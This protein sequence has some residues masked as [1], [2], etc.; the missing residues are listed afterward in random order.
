[1]ANDGE[2]KAANSSFSLSCLRATG[3][4]DDSNRGDTHIAST[5]NVSFCSE[6]RKIS[7]R[8]IKTIKRK[9]LTCTINIVKYKREFVRITE[10]L[11]ML[12]CFI[13]KHYFI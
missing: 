4:P 12:K 6:P 1:M 2:G 5:K 10:W 11:V 13:T 9:S 7:I 3:C 8:K